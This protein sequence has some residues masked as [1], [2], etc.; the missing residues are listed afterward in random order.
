MAITFERSALVGSIW[1]DR[2]VTSVNDIPSYLLS[3]RDLIEVDVTIAAQPLLN[4]ASSE[5]TLDD[6]FVYSAKAVILL[7]H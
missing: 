7:S 3:S 5:N 4:G 6:G 1:Y 2:F